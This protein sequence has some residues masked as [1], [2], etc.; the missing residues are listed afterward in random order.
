MKR[1][2]TGMLWAVVACLA[3]TVGCA[4]AAPGDQPA[5]GP[6]ELQGCW[7]LLSFEVQGESR[8]PIGG[9]EPR[10]V[11]KGNKVQYGGGEAVQLT[12]DSTTSPRIIDLKFRDPDR[13]YEGIYIVEKDTLKICL[14]GRADAKE[15]PGVFST[16][17]QADWRLLVFEREKAAPTN[18][19]EGLPAFAGIR[20]RKDA[21][22][23]AIVVDE[24]IKGSPAE[25][26]GLKKDDVILKVGNLAVADL[27]ATVAAVR[28][29]KPGAK[30]EFQIAR[31]GKEMTITIPVGV[32]PLHFTVLLE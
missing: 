28:Q 21:N 5:A 18:P 26:A 16:K 11:I 10:W 27:Q 1:V 15:R 22:S 31:D 12:A 32:L 25:K 29:A 2:Y 30:L 19:T 3:L 20:L 6:A 7:K 17:D 23:A 4:S 8:E 13:A 9:G 24:P 14:N